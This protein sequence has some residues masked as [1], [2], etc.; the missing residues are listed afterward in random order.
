[1]AFEDLLLALQNFRYE[2]LRLTINGE[3]QGEVNV[4]VSLHGSNPEHRDAQPY[5]FNMN[6]DGQLGDM[7]RQSDAAYRIPTRIEQCLT[8]LA[9]GAK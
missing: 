9:T 1:M 6:I 4:A 2:R 8:E 7:L 3:A 5:E